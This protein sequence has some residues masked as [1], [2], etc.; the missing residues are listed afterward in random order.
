VS[1]VVQ[2]PVPLRGKAQVKGK[3]RGWGWL[4]LAAAA[5]AVAAVGAWYVHARRVHASE[6][7]PGG[8]SA[9][10]TATAGAVVATTRLSPGGIVRTSSQIGSV[11][12][13]EEADLFAKVSGYLKTLNVDYGTHVKKG[14]LLAEIDD[15]EVVK[16]KEAA[17]AEVVQAGAMVKQAQARIETARADLKAAQAA[18][19]QTLAEI[20]RAISKRSYRAKVLERYKDLVVRE[21]VAQSVVDEEQRNYEA[22][23]ADE[24][25]AR[26][27]EATAR[28]QTT[29]AQAKVDQA[30][31]DF[32]EAEA[33][34][35]VDESALARATVMEAYTRISSPYDG[36]VTRRTFFP[37]AFIRSAADGDGRPLLSVARTDKVRV[38]TNVPDLA[39]PMTDV[40]D[41]A[42]VTLDALPDRVFKG[43]VSRFADTEDVT[44]RTMHTEIDL[45]NPDDLIRPGM[46]GIARIFLETDTKRST[47]P[48]SCLVGETRGDKAD[49]Y[50][51]KDA[52]AK[53]TQVK[54]SA[55]DGLRVEI[56]DGLGPDDEVIVATGS[57]TDGLPVR[58]A[59]TAPAA[60][61]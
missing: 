5:V 24:K 41:L 18:V 16:E 21:A 40:G 43:T 54:I 57:V 61:K 47:L 42:E 58:I 32:A 27:A 44:S 33:H 2:A 49:V 59:P 34:V 36:V 17:A 60:S 48:A 29:A 31:A 22:A 30:Q 7:R 35:K 8:E 14:Q 10:A 39:V 55:D 26:A 56:L 25:A 37:G 53:K 9:R 13:F 19:E 50:V 38:V 51:V 52:K 6:G 28:A 20:D 45:P 4:L 15:P 12:A 3:G 23:V 11:E 46:S 1:N